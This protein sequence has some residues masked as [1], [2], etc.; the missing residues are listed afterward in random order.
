MMITFTRP[1]GQRL[2]RSFLTVTLATWLL[3]AIAVWAGFVVN[4]TEPEPTGE[5]VLLAMVCLAYW[6]PIVLLTLWP[7]TIPIVCGLTALVAYAHLENNDHR[8]HDRTH[9]EPDATPNT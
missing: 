9:P 6:G 3:A 7:V 2:L 1:S 5:Y 8:R 4:S